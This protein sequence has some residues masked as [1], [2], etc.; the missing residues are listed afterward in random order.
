MTSTALRLS[1][2]I[3]TYLDD[4]YQEYLPLRDGEVASY[5]PELALGSADSFAIAIATTDG[6]IYEVGD[7]RREFTIQSISKALVYGLA[8]EDNGR[9]SVAKKIGVEPTGDAF[10]SISLEPSSGRPLNPMINA[11]AIATTSLIAGRS[12]EDKLDRILTLFSI[13]AGR[14]LTIDESVYRSESETGHRNRAIGHMLRNF[15]IIGQ[16]PEPALDLYFKQC[17]INVQCRDL[18]MA[19][20]TL[21]N[22]GVNPTTGER[23][24][25]TDYLDDVLSVMT[26]CGMYDYAGEWV[27]RIGLPAKS[28]VGGGIMAVLPG[29]LGI[30]V[31]SPPL[32]A[33]GNSVRGVRVCERLS[34][35]LNLHFLRPPRASASAVRASYTLGAIRSKRRRRSHQLDT[36]SLHGTRTAVF[37]LQGELNFAAIE[38]VVRAVM[39]Q[40]P[41]LETVVLDLKR[42]SEV[43][44]VACRM[45]LELLRSLGSC[46]KDVAFTNAAHLPYLIRYIEERLEPADKRYWQAFSELDSAM[47]WCED[48]ILTS[49][50]K[51]LVTSEWVPLEQNQLCKHLAPEDLKYL[52]K[53]LEFEQF[54]KGQFLV[55]MGDEADRIFLMARGEVSVTVVLPTGRLKRLST[56]SPG[57]SFG[58]LALIEGGLRGADVRA[59]QPVECY[60]LTQK[61]FD[62]FALERPLLQIGLLRNILRTVTTTQSRLTQEVMALGDG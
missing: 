34:R 59:D 29:G 36:L 3:Q 55:K 61:A 41:A 60:S 25:A 12:E 21:A 45:L 14:S 19:A 22:G 10:N 4:L 26:T 42:V 9:E 16:N 62:R 44:E 24:I 51:Q 7:V 38:V 52:E 1:S 2:P 6:R 28:G 48:K 49:A 53:H 5:I 50:G 11:G 32:D 46:G 35:D 54:E 17:S 37:E 8:L 15:D 31:Y 56:I 18:A 39:D 40:A 33:R 47:E 57:M 13:Y 58:E 27:Y 23:V 43:E 30:G 20:A